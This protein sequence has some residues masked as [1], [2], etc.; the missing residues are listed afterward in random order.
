MH[1]EAPA[2]IA[3]VGDVAATGRHSLRFTDAPGLQRLWEPHLTYALNYPPGKYRFSVDIQNS[4]QAPARWYMEFRDWRQAL[5]VGPTFAGRPDGTLTAC[6]KFGSETDQVRELA[7]I[8]NGTWFTVGIEFETGPAA[9]RTYALMLKA[10]GEA[11]RVFR[12]LPFADAGFQQPTWFGISS[13]SNEHAVFHVDNFLL[14]PAAPDFAEQAL[15]T[16]AI[17]GL[18][19]ERSPPAVMR[20]KDQLALHWKFDEG[21]G[22][23]LVDRSGNGLDGDLGSVARA[24]GEF[25][26][27]LYLDG[28]AAVAEVADCPLLHLGTADF[29]I[30]CWIC[31]T[32]LDVDSAHKRRRLLDKGRYPDSW[33][34]V[35]I[36][37]DGRIQMELADADKQTGTTV[38]AGAVRQNA[39]NHVAI[40]VDRRNFQ[41][42]YYLNGRL[43]STQPL[44]PRSAGTWTWPTN[45]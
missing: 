25:G 7:V 44:P 38:S 3:V 12:D 8:P 33:W 10:A 43:D 21:K 31:P 45:R 13:L 6:G 39:W 17:Q 20:N 40:V 34:N 32:Q 41:T 36:Q 22:Y 29:T 5:S 11:E 15:R 18:S 26:H 2:A 9:P 19:Q 37:S 1:A 16:P 30:E 4:K 28:S 35:D 27:A 42:R 23:R 14:G 24:R